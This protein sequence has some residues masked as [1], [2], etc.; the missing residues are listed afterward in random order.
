MIGAEAKVADWRDQHGACALPGETGEPRLKH[1]VTWDIQDDVGFVF[2][3]QK[4]ALLENE[5]IVMTSSNKRKTTLSVVHPGSDLPDKSLATDTWFS[6]PVVTKIAGKEQIVAMSRHDKVVRLFDVEN[7]SSKVVYTLKPEEFRGRNLCP[8]NDSTMAVT[9]FVKDVETGREED[10][11]SMLNVSE[12]GEWSLGNV[13]YVPGIK[14]IYDVVYTQLVDGSPCLIACS[15]KQVQAVD[16]VG[17]QVRWKVSSKTRD[18]GKDFTPSSLCVDKEKIVNVVDRMQHA[19]YFVSAKSGSVLGKVPLD[20]HQIFRPFCVAV[21][22][23]SVFVAHK[24]P[25]NEKVQI[26]K[27]TRNE[28]SFIDKCNRKD[29]IRGQASLKMGGRAGELEKHL[30]LVDLAS[31][32]EITE[33]SHSCVS[34]GDTQSLDS[35]TGSYS[36]ITDANKECLEP[37]IFAFLNV[38]NHIECPLLTLGQKKYFNCSCGDTEPTHV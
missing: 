21:L 10:S 16:I 33:E 37:K 26:S 31:P 22:N 24:N 19:L 3:G 6:S 14:G 1:E 12:E 30:K 4:F 20:Q 36:E 7:N 28:Q 23:E 25:N 38:L 17:G 8:I 13:I 32:P 15:P 35:E 2:S 11:I 34:A 18:V 9:G 29:M 5:A 27:F